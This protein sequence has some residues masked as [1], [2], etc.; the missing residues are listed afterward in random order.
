[1]SKLCTTPTAALL[2]D[3]LD[4]C[5]NIEGVDVEKVRGFLNGEVKRE[6]EA[7]WYESLQRGEPDW[8]IY[9]SDEYLAEAWESWERYSRRY[10]KAIL[11]KPRPEFHGRFNNEIIL[12]SFGKIE[13]VVDIG[14]GL[15]YSTVALKEIFPDAEVYGTNL[16]DTKQTA[17]ARQLLPEGGFHLIENIREVPQ[18]RKTLVFASEFFE[19]LINPVRSLQE[20]IHILH[21]KILVIANTFLSDSPGHFPFYRYQDKIVPRGGMSRLFN[22]ELTQNRY[23]NI[24]TGLW[25]NRPALWYQRGQGQCD[26]S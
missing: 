22:R 12:Q 16:P 25:N 13:T 1:M 20:I 2:Q 5:S 17:F 8:S 26:N 19:H 15:G 14:C 7:I 4:R 9:D 11:S 24:R 21:P 6:M 10:L 23:K 18:P 3:F